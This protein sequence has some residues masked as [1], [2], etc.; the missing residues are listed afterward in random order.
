MWFQ[1]MQNF[2]AVE[3]EADLQAQSSFANILKIPTTRTGQLNFASVGT[4]D[5]FGPFAA[6]C[7]GCFPRSEIAWVR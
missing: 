6:L 1:Q 2:D 5:R 3:H 7:Q 4:N